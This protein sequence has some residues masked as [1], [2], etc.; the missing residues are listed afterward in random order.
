MCGEQQL[1]QFP[2]PATFLQQVTRSPCNEAGF[3]VN[4]RTDRRQEFSMPTRIL[5]AALTLAA[6]AAPID[7]AFAARSAKDQALYEKAMADCNGPKWPNGARPFI[8]YSGGW[9]RCVE[10]GSSRR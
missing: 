7:F 5:I 9:Y 8:N 3:R 2:D 1:Q 10:P 6:A 4:C